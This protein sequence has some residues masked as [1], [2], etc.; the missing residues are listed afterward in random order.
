MLRRLSAKNVT[1]TERRDR[2]DLETL[3]KQDATIDVLQCI[4]STE[5]G[6]R[7]PDGTNKY[8]SWD[9]ERLIEVVKRER[10][11]MK[12]DGGRHKASQRH[13]HGRA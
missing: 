10:Q 4:E 13:T 3:F 7:L 6:K 9:I 2:R 11:G 12:I 1:I 5:V 8:D